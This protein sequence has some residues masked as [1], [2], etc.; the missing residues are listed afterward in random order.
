MIKKAPRESLPCFAP[1]LSVPDCIRTFK[2]SRQKR[3]CN[4]KEKKRPLGNT[5]MTVTW[6]SDKMSPWESVI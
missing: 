6:I 5:K 4:L 1:V 3:K 2:V